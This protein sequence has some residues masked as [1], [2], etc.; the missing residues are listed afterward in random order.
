[1][2]FFIVL[3]VF[4]WGGMINGVMM[5]FGVWYKLCIDLI[6]CFLI[7]VLLFYGMSIF[8]GLMMLIK[9][10]NVFSYNI[11]WIIGY[12]YFGVFGWVVMIIFGVVYVMMLWLFDCCWMFFVGWINVY[13]WFF[14]I[15]MVFYIVVMWV[16]G[17]M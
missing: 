9:I 3:L 6:I 10:V 13:F 11:D 7:V 17:I 5:F 15:G 2:V 4:S 14:I 1:M 8:E 12:V 16:F